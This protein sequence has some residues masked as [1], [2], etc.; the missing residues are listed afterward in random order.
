MASLV[1]GQK[2]QKVSPDF[3]A[4]PDTHQ[5]TRTKAE[6]GTFLPV[7]SPPN[8]QAAMAGRR[9]ALCALAEDDEDEQLDAACSGLTVGVQLQR[10]LDTL[11]SNLARLT[12]DVTLVSHTHG[13]ERRLER[14]I[15]RRELQA[16][17]KSV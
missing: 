1:M 6:R 5:L 16:A 7:I 15:D 11:H 10:L 14:H 8:H 9:P 17:V 13:R 3:A 2:F 4:S 12:V